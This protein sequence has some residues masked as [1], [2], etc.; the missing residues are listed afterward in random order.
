MEGPHFIHW[1]HLDYEDDDPFGLNLDPQLNDWPIPQPSM[2][3]RHPAIRRLG[4]GL[5]ED[6]TEMSL[7]K[8][9]DQNPS[10]QIIISP[11]FSPTWFPFT[12][13]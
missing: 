4:Y 5:P 9:H 13:F 8:S 2:P 11:P 1:P 12:L 10:Y 7:L 3:P 6:G